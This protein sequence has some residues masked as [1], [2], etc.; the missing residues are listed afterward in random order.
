MT[1]PETE[2]TFFYHVLAQLVPADRPAFAERV[3]ERLQTIPD[4][5][6]GDVDRAVRAALIGLWTPPLDAERRAVTRWDRTAPRFEKASR[7][8]W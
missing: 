4:P 7:R 5:G 8:A 2:R 3:A 1:L 6:P